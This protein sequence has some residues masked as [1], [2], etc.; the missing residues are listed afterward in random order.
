MI[1]RAIFSEEHEIFRS[2]VRRFI[3]EEVM[4]HHAEWE[5]AGIVPRDLWLKAGKQGFLCSAVPEEYGGSGGDFLHS[6]IMVE[7]MA[8]AGA[9]GPTFYLHSEIVAPYLVAYG[10]EEQK[11]KWLPKMATG[12]VVV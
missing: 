5:K 4:P 12:E 1:P 10:T 2:S 7:E 8:L 11:Q 3:A 9:T 6:T